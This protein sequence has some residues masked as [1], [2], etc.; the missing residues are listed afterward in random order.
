MHYSLLHINRK[1]ILDYFLICKN[2]VVVMVM[3]MFKKG[4]DKP[5]IVVVT[6]V[7]VNTFE[8]FSG[9]ALPP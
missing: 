2:I 3:P 5:P 7:V 1:V 4:K 6:I 9:R 8:D